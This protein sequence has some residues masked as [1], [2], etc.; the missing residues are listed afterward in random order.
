MPKRAGFTSVFRVCSEASTKRR[1]ET[2]TGQLQ[3]PRPAPAPRTRK[4]S[5]ESR[6][7][8][9]VS[10]RETKACYLMLAMEAAR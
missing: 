3:I 2:E 4:I 9:V 5:R 8:N 1:N 10:A 7:L 6:N